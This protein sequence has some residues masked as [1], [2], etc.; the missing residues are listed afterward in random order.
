MEDGSEP[1][2][3]HDSYLGWCGKQPAP[4]PGTTARDGHFL[5]EFSR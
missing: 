3:L 2:F 5:D 1:K 4:F